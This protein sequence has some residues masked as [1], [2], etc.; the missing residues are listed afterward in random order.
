MRQMPL[1]ARIGEILKVCRKFADESDKKK[2][3][4]KPKLDGI[5]ILK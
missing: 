3:A 1:V 4:V 2:P 5:L